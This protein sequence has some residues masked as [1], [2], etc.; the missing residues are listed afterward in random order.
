MRSYSFTVLLTLKFFLCDCQGL[1]RLAGPQ[2]VFHNSRFEPLYRPFTAKSLLTCYASCLEAPTSCDAISFNRK[3]FSCDLVPRRDE[4]SVVTED[5]WVSVILVQ[6]VRIKLM[7]SKVSPG[8]L[9]VTEDYVVFMLLCI[10]GEYGSKSNKIGLSLDRQPKRKS[11]Q[12][13]L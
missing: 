10:K 12:L 4:A 11:F 1:F 9:S 5:N 3:S 13:S 6:Q 2:R 7:I 8:G